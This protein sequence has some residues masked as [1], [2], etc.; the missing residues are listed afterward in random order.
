MIDNQVVFGQLTVVISFVSHNLCNSGRISLCEITIR[1]TLLFTNKNKNLDFF[2]THMSHE[3][4]TKHKEG[5]EIRT[6]NLLFRYFNFN[7]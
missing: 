5:K 7:Y 3:D 4:S 1:R 2:F 6:C